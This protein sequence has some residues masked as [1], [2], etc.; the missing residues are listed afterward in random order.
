MPNIVVRI[1]SLGGGPMEI[2]DVVKVNNITSGK[3]E[4]GVFS[5]TY[6]K[7]PSKGKQVKYL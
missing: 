5:F 2:H 1:N 6:G 7:D 3:L 4:N